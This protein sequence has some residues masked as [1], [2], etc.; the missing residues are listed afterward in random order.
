MAT[1]PQCGKDIKDGDWTCGACGAPVVPAAGGGAAGDGGASF[2]RPPNAAGGTAAPG[3]QGAAGGLSRAML[4]VFAGAAVAI[5]AIVAVWFFVLRGGG[6]EQFVG[7]WTAVENGGGGLVIA[8]RDG[9]MQITITGGGEQRSGP[10]KGKLR[11]DTLEITLEP[12]EGSAESEVAA[13]F[14]KS[15][16]EAFIEDFRMVLTLRPGDGRLLLDIEGEP[17]T[18][19]PAAIPTTEFVKAAAIP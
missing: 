6:G 4:V 11:G 12:A 2:Y 3:G 10:F 16:F 15:M 18:G 9:E 13:E 8:K 5:I 14:V 19:V 1:C 17:K 7:T